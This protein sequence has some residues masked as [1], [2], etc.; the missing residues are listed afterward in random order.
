[1]MI[2]IIGGTGLGEALFGEIAGQDREIETPFGRPSSPVRLVDWQGLRVALLARHGPGHALNPSQVPYRANLYALKSVGVTHVLAS[3][4]VGSLRDDIAPRDLVIVD[5]AIDRTYRRAPTFFDEGL[6]VHV[7]LAEPFCPDLRQLLLSVSGRVDTHVHNRG[8]YVCMEG[9]GFSTRAE[10]LQ[11]RAWGGDVI[12]MTALPEAKLAREA[13]LSYALVALATDYDCW[14]P[15]AAN[16][17]RDA[18]LAEIIGHLKAATQ[19]AI[20]LLRAALETVARQPLPPSPFQTALDL[21]V[22]SE[23]SVLTPAL[24]ARYGVLLERYLRGRG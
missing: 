1:M 15:H 10:S 14:R 8:V 17:P 11:H 22:W 20:T 4:A 3:G 7:E 24:R 13:E 2:G 6:A 21:A 18:L 9:P 5:Q 19:N 16:V 23:R 12:G